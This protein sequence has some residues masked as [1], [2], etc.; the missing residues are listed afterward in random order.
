[1]PRDRGQEGRDGSL[2]AVACVLHGALVELHQLGEGAVDVVQPLANDIVDG[3][4]SGSQDTGANR[5][6]RVIPI[7]VTL[8]HLGDARTSIS[9]TPC[10]SSGYL[11][12]F[13]WQ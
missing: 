6:V 12:E 1:M 3:A 10:S 11:V 7:R 8:V 4:F 2:E 9:V 5:T 13:L